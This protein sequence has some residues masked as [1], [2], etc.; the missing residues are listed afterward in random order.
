MK[1]IPVY[2]PSLTGKEKE[3]VNDC[4]DS[5]WISSKGSYIQR[6][7]TEFSKH[8]SAQY[9]TTVSNG[10]VAIHLALIALG[11]SEGDEVIVPTLTYIASVNAINYTGAI[12]VFV[13]SDA[14]TWQ[15]SIEDI[16]NKITNKTKAIMCVHLYGQPCDMDAIL[17]IANEFNLFVIEDCAEAFGS[18][19]KDKYVGTFG[20]ISTFSFFGNKT[21]TTGEGGMVVTNDKTLYER[22]V[23]YK[24]Q[25]LAAHRQYWHDVIGYNYRM[26]NICAA[27]GL[28]QLEQAE[29]FINRKRNIA[30]IYK[31]ELFNSPVKVHQE[32]DNTFHTYWMVSILTRTAEER[33]ELRNYLS[34]NSIETRPLF[35]PVHTMPMYSGKYQKHP[36]AEDLGWR[37]MNLPSYPGMTDEQVIY[38]CN[39]IKCFYNE[40]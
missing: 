23:H 1:Y 15:V 18:K 10:T 30:E 32:S 29:G 20:D 27:I 22:C 28:A 2:E 36:V 6:F 33:E 25:G 9:A 26:T 17:E 37:G 39:K 14:E 21:I 19:Y 7:E 35:Y 4:L 31:K 12:P 24:G 3:Y 38:I 5:T 8:I 40:K 13:D 16:R 34:E 11:I